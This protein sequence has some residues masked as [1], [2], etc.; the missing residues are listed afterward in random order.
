M[1]V[2]N[3][4]LRCKPAAESPDAAAR[5]AGR[6][7]SAR[8]ADR[9]RAAGATVARRG[10]SVAPV[11]ATTTGRASD[12]RSHETR[13]RIPARVCRAVIQDQ[14]PSRHR[15][16]R[17]LKVQSPKSLAAGRI[18]IHRHRGS[19]PLPLP[20]RHE[21][22]GLGRGA[23]FHRIGAANWNPLSLT[24]SPLLRRGEREST[25][26]VVLVSKAAPAGAPNSGSAR[27]RRNP[28]DTPI[29]NSAL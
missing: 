27:K 12:H 10:L 9:R 3:K 23:P 29:L 17:T 26:G 24:L 5:F 7:R 16:G 14:S 20:A 1:A 28:R 15:L 2:G 4:P 25:T 11:F 18:W 19:P 21:G 22:R 8:P 13:G 6:A